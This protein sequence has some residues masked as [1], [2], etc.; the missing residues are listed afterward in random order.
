MDPRGVFGGVEELAESGDGVGRGDG[1][2]GFGGF[3][4]G[5]FGAGGFVVEEG[6]DIEA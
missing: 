4:G 3:R 2:G 5:V 6:V 1:V